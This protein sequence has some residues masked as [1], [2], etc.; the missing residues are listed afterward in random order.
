MKY[1][2]TDNFRF[3]GFVDKIITVSEVAVI[4][5]NNI[6]II[7]DCCSV[8]VLFIYPLL[9]VRLQVNVN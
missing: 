4:Y 5:Y 9:D 7:T 8:V 3:I 6:K 1:K 2:N